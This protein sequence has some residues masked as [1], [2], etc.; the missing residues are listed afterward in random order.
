VADEQELLTIEE[1]AARTGLTVRNIRSHV[2]RGL[3]PAPYLKG[4]TGFYGPEHV[5]RLQLV[6]GLQQQGFN[7]AAISNL[8]SGPAAPSPEETVAFYRTALGAWLTDSPEVWDE[9]DLADAFGVQPDPE[10]LNRLTSL[11][12]L[13][14]QDDGRVRVTNPTLLRVGRQLAALGYGVQHLMGVLTVLIDGS[15]QVADA[16][17]TMFLDVQWRDYLDA[18]M[19][20]ERLPELQALIE[21]LQPLA[22]QAVVAAFQQAMTEATAG[23]FQ[24]EAE[25]LGGDGSHSAAG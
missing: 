9:Q 15:R 22:S 13:V 6:T 17:V 1:L 24:R 8:V 11:G 4:R 5:A 25:A 14:R 3:L 23:A 19:P 7:L 2:T 12:V 20:P 10:L 21:Q 18:G 16:F